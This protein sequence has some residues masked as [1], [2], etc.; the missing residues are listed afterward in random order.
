MECVNQ[1][2]VSELANS[3]LARQLV[4]A[5]WLLEFSNEWTGSKMANDLLRG[6]AESAGRVESL[7]L[8]E[9]AEVDRWERE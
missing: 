3:Q 4:Y 6:I 7:I 8:E 1:H 2:V 5:P 9:E